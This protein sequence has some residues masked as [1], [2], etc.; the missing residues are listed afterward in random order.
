[1]IVSATF[2]P[3]CFIVAPVSTLSTIK[4]LSPINGASSIEPYGFIIET[5]VAF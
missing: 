2:S 3:F 1:M 4:S 5:G